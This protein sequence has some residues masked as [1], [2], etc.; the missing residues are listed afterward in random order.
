MNNESGTSQGGAGDG[1]GNE[2]MPN[3]PEA[4]EINEAIEEIAALKIDRNLIN[5]KINA[6]ITDMESKGIARAA[7]KLAIKVHEMDECERDSLTFGFNV[8]RDAM[9]QQ[10]DLFE[11]SYEHVPDQHE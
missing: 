2:E 11:T 1:Q 10:M 4:N 6:V 5:Q 7:F 9:N 3:I 8:C